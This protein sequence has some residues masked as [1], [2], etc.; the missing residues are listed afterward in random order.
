MLY[1]GPSDVYWESTATICGEVP[2]DVTGLTAE[3]LDHYLALVPTPIAV[4]HGVIRIGVLLR[5]EPIDSINGGPVDALGAEWSTWFADDLVGQTAD[6]AI[7]VHD[8]PGE[9][10]M[11]GPSRALDPCVA[12]EEPRRVSVFSAPCSRIGVA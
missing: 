7:G 10:W 1:V 3:D 12:K 5:L 2:H 6:D 8:L 4:Q 11:V 9:G